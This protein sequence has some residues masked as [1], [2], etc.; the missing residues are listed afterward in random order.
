MLQGTIRPKGLAKLGNIVA[1]NLVSSNVSRVAK[2]AGSIRN[3]WLLIL[4]N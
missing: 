2:L 1:G 3:V 4:P